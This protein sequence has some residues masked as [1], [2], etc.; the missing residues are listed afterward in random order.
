MVGGKKPHV[1]PKKRHKGQHGGPFAKP[2]PKKG[3]HRK[4]ESG[5]AGSENWQ[6]SWSRFTLG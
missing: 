2:P 4:K 3:P 6:D 1:Q 5:P